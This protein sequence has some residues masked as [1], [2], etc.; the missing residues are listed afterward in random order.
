MSMTIDSERAIRAGQ[1]RRGL[2]ALF[3]VSACL[4][5][6]SRAPH[7]VLGLLRAALDLVRP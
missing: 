5:A 4:V 3:I 7:T 1:V 6:I 2:L